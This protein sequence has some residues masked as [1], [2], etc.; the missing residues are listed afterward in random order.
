MHRKWLKDNVEGRAWGW[1]RRNPQPVGKGAE[2]QF[3][4]N[5]LKIKQANSITAMDPGQRKGQ[6]SNSIEIQ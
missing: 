4:R 5:R 3:S 6:T 1:L 2:Q